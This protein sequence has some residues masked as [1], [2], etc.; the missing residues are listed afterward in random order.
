[1]AIR[2]SEQAYG[3]TVGSL[4]LSSVGPIAFGPD[5]ILFVADSRAATIYAV[6]L[7]VPE[8][9]GAR[10]LD[11]EGI[12]QRLA[13]YL[14]CPAEDVDV[15][16]LAVD[17]RSQGV[18]L[19]VMRG[20]GEGA[21]PV[22]LRVEDGGTL[23]EVSLDNVPFSQTSIADAPA[24]NDERMDVRVLRDDEPGGQAY[25]ARGTILQLLREPLRVMTVTDMKYV[26][27]TLVVAGASNE[28]FTSTLRQIPFPFQGK[29]DSSSLEIFHVSH[30]KWETHSPIRTFVAYDDDLSV[31]ASYTCTP[32]VKFSL[33]DLRGSKQARGYT[34]AELGAMNTPL[35]M[36]SYRRNG[37][38]YL[39]VS[40]SR[41]E[42]YRLRRSDLQAQDELTTPQAP[43]GAPREALPHQGVGRMALL[44]DSTVLML[45]RLD[46]RVDLRSYSTDSL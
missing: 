39:L 17:P 2:T 28:E 36:V 44:G 3:L 35:G 9:S 12:D 22:I 6:A 8:A 7:D 45:Q 24:E 14:G 15:R 40:N 18:Y 26:D 31:L 16:G 1:M 33:S 27:G 19:S 38:E 11:V 4:K 23:A 25:D 29:A 20:R 13:A 30:G 21:T 43:V 34:V 41:H 46:G 42:L 10:S 37:D 32:V 5:S